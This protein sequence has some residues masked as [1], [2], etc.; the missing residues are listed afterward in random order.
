MPVLP[1]V[2]STITERPGSTS[3]CSSARSI[4]ATPMRSLIEPPGFIC[5]SLATTSAPRP[6]PNRVS[7][8]IGVLPMVAAACSAIR[9][10]ASVTLTWRTVAP[11]GLLLDRQLHRHP[12]V[13]SADELV[14]AGLRELLLEVDAGLGG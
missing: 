13:E 8:T 1:E 6:V 3:P 9:A 11:D 10:L 12:A 7:E 4:I 5:S 14:I 2:G